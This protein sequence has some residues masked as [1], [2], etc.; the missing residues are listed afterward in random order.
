MFLIEKLNSIIYFK[1]TEILKEQCHYVMILRPSI[2]FM[3]SND[4]RLQYYAAMNLWSGFKDTNQAEKIFKDQ[5]KFIYTQNKA[6]EA[7]NNTYT[8]N[9][10]THD[11]FSITSSVWRDLNSSWKEDFSS[12]RKL[13]SIIAKTIISSIKSEDYSP[14][15]KLRCHTLQSGFSA[16][17][18]NPSSKLPTNII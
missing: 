6:K 8:D 17:N 13:S 3:S 16:S 14:R 1:H 12:N 2:L 10:I 5:T 4:F 15:S 7:G 18:V 11:P 9:Y